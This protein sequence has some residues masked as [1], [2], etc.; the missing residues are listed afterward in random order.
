MV[1][2]VRDPVSAMPPVQKKGIR[3]KK[4]NQ[5]AHPG[6]KIPKNAKRDGM[7]RNIK[8]NQNGGISSPEVSAGV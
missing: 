3:N 1:P 4:R 7:M 8:P 5:R 6:A 2:P